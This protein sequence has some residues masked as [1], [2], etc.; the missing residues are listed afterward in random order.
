MFGGTETAASAAEWAVAELMKSSDDLKRVQQE[1]EDVVG[2][3]RKVH[4]PDLE[5]YLSQMRNERNP[6]S[7]PSNPSPPP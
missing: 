6:T 7:P 4:E 3:N 5:T 2:L 1:L